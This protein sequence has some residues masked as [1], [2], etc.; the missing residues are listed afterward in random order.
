MS[1]FQAKEWWGTR[2]GAEETF[3]SGSLVV[4]N[5]DNA[6]S[7][8]GNLILLPLQLLSTSINSMVF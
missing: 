1:L 8:A 3:E 5:V 4:G 7:G 6:S 2:I